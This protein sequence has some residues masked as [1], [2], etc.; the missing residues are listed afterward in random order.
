MKD[1]KRYIA[2]V[3]I[4][5]TT[6]C[7]DFL[8]TAP[9]D[10]LSP[11]TTWKSEI[12]AQKFA[13][14]C[15]DGWENGETI[16]YLDCNTD[17]GYNNFE[18]ENYKTIANGTMSP[19]GSVKDFY[20]YSAIRRCNTFLEKVKDI[21]FA[22]EQAKTDLIGQ[23]RTIRAYRYFVMNWW[24]GGV[25]IIDN[26]GS[27][28]EAQVPRNTEKEVLD[29]VNNELDKA[30]EELDVT[31]TERGR[32]A[33]GVAMAIRMRSAL[34]Y[35]DFQKAKE[36]AEAI[37]DLNQYFLESNYGDLFK[38]SGQGSKEIIA[39]VQYLNVTRDLYTIGQMYNNSD[40]GWSSIVPTQNL[41]NTYEMKDGLTKEESELYDPTHPF[42]NRDPRMEMTILYPGMN[43]QGGI[44]NTLDKTIDGVANSNYPPSANNA[45]KT[46]L[47]WRKYLDPID[48]YTGGI[49]ASN[50]CPIVIRYAEVLLTYAEATNELSGPSADIYERLNKIRSRVGMPDVDRAKYGTKETLRELIRRERSVELAGEGVRRPD[51]MRWKDNNGKALAETVLNQTLERIVG[52]IDY[53]EADPSKRAVIDVNAPDSDRKIEDRVFKLHNRY[54]PIPQ[55]SI[56]D[57]PKLKQN[58]GYVN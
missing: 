44:I 36:M 30:I 5:L 37:I 7:S 47:S 14:G 49:F 35:N 57:N 43:W 15:Y 39:A 29:F 2:L 25:P 17:F 58:E 55:S 10:A 53:N 23:V 20:D 4:A 32:I 16:L 42:A 51:I 45:S 22:N 48:Q 11:S 52:T 13:V 27:A 21:A 38:V 12:D 18:W 9:L 26:Y 8:D 3:V 34:Y 33:K 50:A 54:N 46:A 31:P 28:T 24:Y 6:S 40:G 56:D 41:V 1:F 19:S